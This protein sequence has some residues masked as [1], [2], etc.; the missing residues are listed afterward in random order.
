MAVN[1]AFAH[2]LARLFCCI[3]SCTKRYLQKRK[4]LGAGSY[5]QLCS[6]NC[7]EPD[8]ERHN[9]WVPCEVGPGDFTAG[10]KKHTIG[11][12]DIKLK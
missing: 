4:T 12:N 1:N 5:E 10:L 11:A 6:K 3:R 2:R 7:Y 8:R 9:P